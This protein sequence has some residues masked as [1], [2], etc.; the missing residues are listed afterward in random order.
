MSIVLHG[1]P[2]GGG[3]AI[4]RAHLLSQSMDDVVHYSIDDH[5]IAAEQQRFDQAVRATRK[6]LE[7]L[8]GSI[9]ENAPAELGA[10]LSLHIM[11]L[12]DVTLT[13]DP[14]ELIASLRCNAEWALKQQ[15]DT[16]IEQFD[17]IEEDYLRERKHDVLQV[18]ERVFKNLGGHTTELQ[19]SEGLDGDA[20][21]VAHDLS[22]ADM[23]YF[24]DSNV[25]AFVTDVGGATSHTAILGRSLD[26]PSVIALHHARELV[27]E[28]ELIIVDGQQGVL[29]I[30]PEPTVLA[31]YRRRQR[32]CVEARR[33]LSSI[34]NTDAITEDGTP[35]ELLANIELPQDAANVLQAGAV[36][37]GLFRS[38]F[39]FLGRDNLP[40]ED[41]QFD[42]YRMVAELTGG[43][44]VTVRTM[45]LG[46]D[47]SPRWL[48]H[49][50]AENPAL[51][52]TG[53]RLCLAEPL[54][55][56]AQLRA[57]LRASAFGKIRILF[58][59]I[60]SL[61]ELKQ[62]LTQL[63]YAKAELRAE[64]IAFAE[65]VEVG[66]MI[67]I[68]SAALVVGSFIKHVD[69]LSIGTNDLIQYTLAIDR[70]DD[71][72]SHLYDPIHPAVL[73]LISYTIKTASKAGVPVSVCGEM[74]G[75]ARLTRLLLG[76]GL[77][78]FSMHP[79]NL[80]DVKQQVLS[81]HLDEVGPHV[82]RMLRS[83]DPD[84]IADLLQ[85]LNAGPDA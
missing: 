85:Q 66:A 26:L 73:K 81:S 6:Q 41:E 64:G 52:L 5:E 84:R 61:G 2:I 8:W 51:G 76:M 45:D 57:L 4:G 19:L 31:E 13:R 67:E 44:P 42:A 53:I 32:A 48:N 65:A 62:S 50:L 12:S 18:V 47:K 27:R 1:V 22:P 54:M 28:D 46:A 39:L 16:L 82:A 72:V 59:M 38:E 58:P 23:V 15:C 63:E 37:V 49:Q 78:R 3:I 24:K 9:P 21:L 17:A 36:G 11:L 70:N 68:P 60:N 77:R 71:T 20:I 43:A 56:R 34:R 75:D 7:M 29:L 25:A 35:I 69:F 40:S 33:K 30:N 55:F 10:F 80:L 14:R 74:A 79:A 83:E